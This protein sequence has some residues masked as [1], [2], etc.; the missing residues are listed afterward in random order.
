MIIT[1]IKRSNE[2]I[3]LY[4]NNEII[5]FDFYQSDTPQK[6][7][8]ELIEEG[9]KISNLNY[10]EKLLKIVLYSRFTSITNN[11]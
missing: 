1:G 3:T 7:I 10:L 6:I 5:S 9:F 4:T 2:S 11:L 8:A